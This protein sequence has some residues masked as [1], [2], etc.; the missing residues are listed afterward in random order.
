MYTP[1]LMSCGPGGG[2]SIPTYLE[3]RGT[4]VYV[5]Y[6]TQHSGSIT[7][8]DYNELSLCNFRKIECEMSCAYGSQVSRHRD[9]SAIVAF[10]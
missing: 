9:E 10:N 3:F 4:A 2:C 7:T 1:N 8:C 5:T 6:P